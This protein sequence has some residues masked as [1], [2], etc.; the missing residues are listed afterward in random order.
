LK[1]WDTLWDKI[2]ANYLSGKGHVFKIEKLNTKSENNPIKT[3]KR[4]DFPLH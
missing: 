2:F 3:L 1:G 4:Y